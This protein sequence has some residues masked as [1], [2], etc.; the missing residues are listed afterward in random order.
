[1]KLWAILEGMGGLSRGEMGSAWCLEAAVLIAAGARGK[2][3][4]RWEATA[5]VQ[6]RCADSVAERRPCSTGHLTVRL[7]G[8]RSC[9]AAKGNTCPGSEERRTSS[10]LCSCPTRGQEG[11][12]R[13]P[14]KGQQC[15]WLLEGPLGWG[16]TVALAFALE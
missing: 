1:M 16:R 15:Q 13:S 12:E 4:D 8:G 14:R 11:S 10:G 2:L 7:C 6:C 3:G 9:R 5:V